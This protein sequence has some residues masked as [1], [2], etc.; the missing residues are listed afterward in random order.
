MNFQEVT[1]SESKKFIQENI[2]KPV[3]EIL[4]GAKKYP[5]L[6]I[7]ILVAQIEGKNKAKKKLPSW[8]KNENIIYPVKLSMEQCSSESTAHYKASLL[9]GNALIDLTGGFGVDCTAFAEKIKQVFYIEQNAELAQIAA[10]NFNVFEKKNITVYNAKTEDFISDFHEP[11]DWIFID[12]ARRKEGNKVFRLSDCEPDILAL[13]KPLFKISKQILIKT[14]PLLDLDMAL[15]ELEFVKEI[16]IVAVDNECKELL[17]VLGRESCEPEIVAVNIRKETTLDVFRF[18]RKEES[19][20]QVQYQLPM[21]YLYEPNAA[22]LKAGAFKSIALKEGL[23]KL[24]PSS[25]LYTSNAYKENFPGRSFRIL[26]RLKYSKKE[27]LAALPEGKANITVRN[28]PDSVESI[29]KKTGVKDGGT[30]YLFA[31]KDLDDKPVI[32]L[33]EKIH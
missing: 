8:Y 3:E 4:L 18:T 6:N 19:E 26:D 33:T 2:E 30:I 7:P 12:P 14:S 24:N 27:L 11:V 31:T 9:N 15:R 5:L 1:S 32:L 10:H 16:H 21:E 13:K 23:F 29:R 28:F 22:V 25:H 17:F 20:A